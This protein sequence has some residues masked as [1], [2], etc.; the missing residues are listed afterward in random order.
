MCFY[1][2][3]GLL[4]D[5]AVGF[6]TWISPPLSSPGTPPRASPDV[7]RSR[8]DSDATSSGLRKLPCPPSPPSNQLLKLDQVS[9]P[10]AGQSAKERRAELKRLGLPFHSDDEEEA[11]AEELRLSKWVKRRSMEGDSVVRMDV[12]L[13]DEHG[14]I[15][16]LSFRS[17]FHPASNSITSQ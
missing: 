9:L 11:E 1:I 12:P 13:L 4:A 10:N 7:S 8:S 2:S 14:S 6:R 15:A 3:K 17:G 16:Q 5:I